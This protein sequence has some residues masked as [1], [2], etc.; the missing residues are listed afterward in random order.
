MSDRH[1]RSFSD[2]DDVIEAEGVLSEI[3]SLAGITVARDVHQPG[4]RWSVHVRPVVGTETCQVRHVGMAM[5]GRLHVILDEGSE[6][7]IQ[8]GDVYH[9]PPGHD[10]WVVRDEPYECVEWMGARSWITPLGALADRVLATLVFTDMVDSTGTARR[11]GERAWRELLT[12][13]EARVRD[14][15]AWFRGREVKQTGDGVLATFDGAARAIRCAIEL[16]EVAAGLDLTIRTA[17][18]TAEVEVSESDIHGLAVHESARMLGMAGPGEIL[19]SAST[20]ELA[21]DPGLT[22]EDRG[23]YELRGIEGVR[24]LFAV[25]PASAPL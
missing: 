21:G 9:I 19:V 12:V 20:R 3:L 10:A 1:V 17:V 4:W 7:Q 13:H 2:P 8:V 18:H 11:L 22:F 5:R 23:E 14:T 25:A 24:R 6:Y 16:R 15:L